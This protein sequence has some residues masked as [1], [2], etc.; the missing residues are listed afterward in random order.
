MRD[1]GGDS[2]TGSPDVPTR[3]VR[4]AYFCMEVAFDS[5][6]PTYSGGLGVL[7]GDTLHTAADIASPM[8][9]VTLLYRQ[10]YFRQHLDEQGTQSEQPAVWAP[11][12][13]LEPLDARC[14]VL[15]EGRDVHVRAWRYRFQGVTGAEVPVYFLDTDLEENSSWD[16]SLTGWL[17][18]GDVRYR[19]CQEV[20]LGIGGLAMLRALGYEQIGTY[21]MNEGHAALLPLALLQEEL[22]GRDPRGASEAECASVRNRCV[23]TTHT[24]VEPGNDQFPFDLVKEVLGETNPVYLAALPYAHR[25]NLNMTYLALGWSRYA[26]AVS[27][28]HREV[29]QE[30]FPEYT[31]H[32]ITNG[33]HAAAWTS[34]RFAALYDRTAGE[35][36]AGQ[37][38]PA[39]CGRDPAR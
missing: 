33:V 20:L 24:P 11:E 23:F 21:H 29:S 14:T 6:A 13:Y 17:Y 1:S 9:G 16:R 37:F 30:L 3:R 32:A 39:G 4:V 22:G 38:L 10:G 8:A 28:R 26:N 15:I 7:A 19:L 34:P 18:G 36:A 27:R 12:D 2:T 5:A 31:I 35:M 25:S